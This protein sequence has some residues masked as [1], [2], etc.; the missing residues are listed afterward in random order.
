MKYYLAI[1]IGASSGRHIIS[2]LQNGKIVLEEIYRFENGVMERNGHLVWDWQKLFSEIIEGMKRCKEAGK[3]PCSMGIDTWAVDYALL[4]EDD[5]ILGDLYSYR[6]HRNDG[7]DDRVKEFIGEEELYL[8]TGIQKQPFNTIY[9]LMAHRVYEKELLEKA[10]TLLMVPDYFHFLLTGNKVAEY[11]NASTTQ[12]VSPDTKDWDLE[13]IERLGYPK[14]IFC[15]IK[16]PGTPIGN[17]KQDIRDLVGFDCQVVLPATH[18]TGAAVMAVP[19]NTSG[20]KIEDCIYISSG[21]WSLMGTELSEANCTIDSMKKN[22]TNEGGF[23]YRFR[24]LKNIM[25]MWMINSARKEIAKDLDFATICEMASGES[26]CS[27]VDANHQRF[28]APKSM[29][30]EVKNACRETG[31]EVPD[32]IGQVAAVIYNSLARCYADTLKE[33]EE[34]T[35]KYFSCLHVVGGG[36]NAMY[37]NELTA[38]A[39][40]IPVLAGP[41]EATAIGNVVGQM[42]ASKEIKDL[43][44]AKKCIANSFEIRRVTC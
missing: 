8:R 34:C 16:T 44:A 7:M 36:A 27:I 23:D 9:Q 17:L 29:V 33:I 4:D 24:Y 35:G 20:E 32:G 21:T 30:E 18:D 13:L 5:K 25:G 41:I 15:S 14:E 19:A 6:D 40:K 10:K 31:Q 3:I 1:D 11:T 38:K 12:L 37:L 26:I 28:L 2:Y 22:L 39:C 42:I 43:A